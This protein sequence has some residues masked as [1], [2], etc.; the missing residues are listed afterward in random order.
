M[1][2]SAAS[3]YLEDKI[4]DYI[5]DN[6]SFTVPTT[7]LALFTN[8]GEGAGTGSNLEAGTLTDEVDYAAAGVG[9]DR[10]AIAFDAASAGVTQNTATVTFD[11]ATGSWGSVTHIAIMDSD[12]TGAG[13]VLFW[14]EVTT[15]KTIDTADQFQVSA[16]NLTISIS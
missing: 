11:P 15:A 4:L 6:D 2:T 8:V 3:D 16:G 10:Q 1:T 7:Y 9:Y 13:N 14:G 5:F 12:T